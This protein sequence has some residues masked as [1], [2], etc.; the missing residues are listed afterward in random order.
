MADAL[1]SAVRTSRV[2]LYILIA[3]L[4]HSQLSVHVNQAHVQLPSSVQTNV[5]PVDVAE[6][7]CIR[8]MLLENVSQL[9]W[10]YNIRLR[11]DLS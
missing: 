9:T 1:H 3:L 11:H 5:A 6:L 10:R 4:C 8:K 7:L 2:Q